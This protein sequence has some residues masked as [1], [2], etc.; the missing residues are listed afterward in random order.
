L[1]RN[2]GLTRKRKVLS[3]GRGLTMKDKGY[4]KNIGLP[5]NKKDSSNGKSFAK[6]LKFNYKKMRFR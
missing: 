5:K 3:K 4:V 2:K 6:R 1:L